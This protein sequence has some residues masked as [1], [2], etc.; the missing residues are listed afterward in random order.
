MEN[1]MV[2]SALVLVAFT[3]AAA[4]GP[5]DTPRNGQ[6]GEPLPDTFPVAGSGADLPEGVPL[7]PRPGDT[8]PAPRR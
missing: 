8:L 5:E 4:C 1:R 6:I 3:G 2:R 7:P